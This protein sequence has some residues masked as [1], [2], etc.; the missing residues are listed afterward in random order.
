MNDVSASCPAWADRLSE[1]LP[2]TAAAQLELDRFHR[3]ESPLGTTLAA[4]LRLAVAVANRCAE[5]QAAAERDLAGAA[6]ESDEDR[7]ALAFARKLTL[8]GTSITDDDVARLIDARGPDDFVAIVHVVAQANFHQR[9]VLAL[10]AL[11]DAVPDETPVFDGDGAAAVASWSR[12]TYDE[13][14]DR[15]ERQKTRR[16]RVA[17]PLDEAR[18]ARVP[19]PYRERMG[20]VA[21][22]TASFG[23]APRLVEPW[24]RTM[25]TFFREGAL[26]PVLSQTVFWVVTRTNDCFY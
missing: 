26:D 15:V 17:L 8:D 19:S 22:G 6:P 18:L 10:S 20:R 14:R 11:D 4:R 13:L 23:Y 2:R 16:P 9:V 7:E 25:N 3:D 12:H 1:S 24:Y 5:A 21:W